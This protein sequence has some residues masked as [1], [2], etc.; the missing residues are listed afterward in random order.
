VGKTVPLEGHVV[1][2]LRDIDNVPV[3]R[4][5]IVGNY[6][7]IGRRKRVL[8]LV[9]NDLTGKLMVQASVEAGLAR[10]FAHILEFDRNEFYFSDDQ[11]WMPSLWG[12][13]FA[14]VC[15]MFEHAVPIGIKLAEGH[16]QDGVYL[17]LNPA[18]TD[19][20]E[21]GDSLLVIAEDDDSYSPGSLKLTN[22]GAPPDF[23]EPPKPKTKTLLVGWR[24]DIQDMIFELDKWSEP[25]S[26]LVLLSNNDKQDRVDELLH[27]GCNVES[28][29][30]NLSVVLEQENPIFRRELERVD[31]PSF[32]S[33]LILTEELG[34]DG[35][36]SDSR[37]MIC[38]LLCRDLQKEAWKTSQT[39][40]FGR[41]V[42]CIRAGLTSEILDPRTAELMKLANADDHVVSNSLIS[43]A[44][45][46]MSEQADVW[47]LVEDL[48]S[49]EGNEIHIKDVRLYA[50]DGE[51]LTFFEISNRARQR[52]EVAI[53]F[54]RIADVNSGAEDKGIILNPENKSQ[55]IT[56][57]G[58]TV[59]PSTGL[60]IDGDKIVVVSED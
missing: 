28:D 58:P 35:L 21:E 15:F 12:K 45:A 6:S 26:L 9:G 24:R 51:T 40:T 22:C 4:M 46:Q 54:Q 37:S 39:L 55:K 52:C 33:I 20:I 48:F 34:K 5:G 42:P 2:E 30:Q 31:V 23:E 16:A 60:Q 3:V 29:T 8:P 59:D 44:L 7:E 50:H 1:V 41:Q 56:W 53:G 17:M 32:D 57:V 27:A 19:V 11:P 25:G 49:Q 13:R 38:M 14:D 36:S 10:V 18:G 43:M 47:Q